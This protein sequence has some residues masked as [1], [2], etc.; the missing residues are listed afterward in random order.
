MRHERE[1]TLERRARSR[2]RGLV[3]VL[4]AALIVAASLTAVSVSR[5]REVGRQRDE[6][7]I[8]AL[9]GAALSNLGTDPELSVLLALHALNL[10]TERG[11]SVPADT[12]GALHWAMQEAGIEY[13]AAPGRPSLVAGPLGMRG[14]FDVALPT[15]ADAA[16]KGITHSLTPEQCDRY[17][18]T[19][20]CP[21][22]PST[23][24]ADLEAEPIK[25]IPTPPDKPLFGTQVT[26]FGGYD[27]TQVAAL[28][29]EFVPFTLRTGIEVRLVG[30]PGFQ[31]YV[32]DSVAAGD[33]P[34]V[35]VLPQPGTVRDLARQGHL[36]DLGTYIDVDRLKQDRVPTSS[37][38]EPSGTTARGRHRMA[39]STAPSSAST[40]RA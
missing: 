30:N 40:S 21:D 20:T 39:R 6:N 11:R 34:D 28:R 12:V 26:L 37:H 19:A 13:P 24:P 14:V 10:G 2:L 38:W 27:R 4:A 25:A 7:T 16:R 31:D 33:P 35:A 36:I 17:L 32:S 23:F 15:L 3:A 22:L 9:T 5:G 1:L 29:E 18:G 8:N